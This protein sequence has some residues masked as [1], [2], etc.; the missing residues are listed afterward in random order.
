[1]W[2]LKK[3]QSAMNKTNWIIHREYHMFASNLLGPSLQKQMGVCRRPERLYNTVQQKGLPSSARWGRPIRPSSAHN[4]KCSER[5]LQSSLAQQPNLTCEPP[6]AWNS[7][8]GK[9][10]H[11][12]RRAQ[13]A[14][15]RR[16][17]SPSPW[18]GTTITKHP[19]G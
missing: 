11:A 19:S 4:R 13:T 16:R 14:T 18:G 2:T 12:T 3:R 5:R 8:A 10:D 1:M 7:P 9:I 15:P 17:D 6:L